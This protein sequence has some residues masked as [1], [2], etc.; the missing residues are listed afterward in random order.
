MALLLVLLAAGA[1]VVTQVRV[2][3]AARSAA[4]A[5]AAGEGPD[6]VREIVSQVAGPDARAEVRPGDLVE[7]VVTSPLP[8]PIGGWG[9]AA[10]GVA[11]TPAEPTGGGS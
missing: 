6:R 2:T 3:D 11:R 9:T 4:R 10:R 5:V 7:V 1:A 8:G